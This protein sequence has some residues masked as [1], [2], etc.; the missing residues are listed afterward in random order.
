MGEKPGAPKLTEPGLPRPA[1]GLTAQLRGAQDT[2]LGEEEE[3]RGT[4]LG[5][6]P[7]AGGT[8]RGTGRHPAL[9][10]WPPPH[11][12]RKYLRDADRQVLAQRAFVLTVKVLEDTLSELSEVHPAHP[13]QVPTPPPVGSILTCLPRWEGQFTDD[14]AIT[15]CEALTRLAKVSSW[16]VRKVVRLLRQP[17]PAGPAQ[18]TTALTVEQMAKPVAPHPH[19]PAPRSWC[20]HGPSSQLGIP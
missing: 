8:R 17:R 15:S 12:C 20:T 16:L 9:M 1:P 19:P 6:R 18:E 14:L 3:A 4:L 2:V 11:A 13:G 5:S 10:L 7:Q